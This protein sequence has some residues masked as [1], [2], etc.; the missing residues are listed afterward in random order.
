MAAPGLRRVTPPYRGVAAIAAIRA[1]R[2]RTDPPRWGACA[3][4]PDGNLPHGEEEP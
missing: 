2:L 3:G 4:K 1:W